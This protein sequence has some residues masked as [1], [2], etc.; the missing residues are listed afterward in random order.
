MVD[1]RA[2]EIF[3]QIETFSFY[4]PIREGKKVV[5]LGDSR[6]AIILD[7]II[8]FLKL[9]SSKAFAVLNVHKIRANFISVPLL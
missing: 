1:S 9:I 5:Y 3:V 8:F 6:I 7:K 2:T 4:T